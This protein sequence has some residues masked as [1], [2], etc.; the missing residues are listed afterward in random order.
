MFIF[1][2]D[3]LYLLVIENK[4]HQQKEPLK[5]RGLALHGNQ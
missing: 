1:I 5:I 4:Q 3:F 2:I